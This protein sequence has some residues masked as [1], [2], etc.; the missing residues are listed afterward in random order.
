VY[1]NTLHDNATAQ[2]HFGKSGSEMLSY[3]PDHDGEIYLFDLS[4][5]SAAKTQLMDDIPRLV[6]ASG[7]AN[8]VGEFYEVTYNATPAHSDDIHQAIIESEDLEVLTPN[9]GLRRAPGTIEPADTTRLKTQRSL[10]RCSRGGQKSRQRI[11][12]SSHPPPP[13]L[14]DSASSPA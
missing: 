14:S 2:A 10:F 4:G 5:R 8:G 13:N 11:P 12:S 7:D 9:G 3:D 1:N 6:S